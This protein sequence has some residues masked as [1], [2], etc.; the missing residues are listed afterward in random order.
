[1]RTLD[2]I[3]FAAIATNKCSRNKPHASLLQAPEVGGFPM[4]VEV[5]GWLKASTRHKIL[6]DLQQAGAIASFLNSKGGVDIIVILDDNNFDIGLRGKK[7]T[8]S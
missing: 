2:S 5:E 3:K 7:R 4:A 8:L 1:V 6:L